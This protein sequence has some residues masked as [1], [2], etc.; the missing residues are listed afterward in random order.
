[1]LISPRSLQEL[2]DEIPALDLEVL[3]TLATLLEAGIVRRIAFGSQRVELADPERLG[4][5]S[6]LAKRVARPGFRGAPRVGI[7]ASPRRLL[8]ILAALGRIAEAMLPSEAVPSSPIP[9]VLA[10]LRL[11]DGV[12]LDVVGVPLVDAYAPL[13][14]FVL[15]SCASLGLA[16]KTGSAVLE[17]ACSLASVPVVDARPLL[18][19]EDDCDAEHVAALVRRLLESAAGG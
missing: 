6:A 10:T 9:H 3:D 14:S 5:L 2:L 12:D 11:G 17:Q 8:G 16:D 19:D 7:A 4:V 15:P 1:M 13:W 18:G